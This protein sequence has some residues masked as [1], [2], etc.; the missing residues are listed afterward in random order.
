MSNS[1]FTVAGSA[2]GTGTV[3]TVSTGTG[4]TGGPI[5]TSGTVAI[6]NTAV[7]PGSYTNVSLTVNQQ[8]Q[9][10]AAS[11]GTPAGGTVTS[12]ATG[13][14]LTGGPVTTSGTISLV[15]PVVVA[16]GG[17]GL[18]TMANPYGVIVAGT[19]STG[20]LQNIATGSAGQVLA[21]NGNAA[22]PSFQT[23]GAGAGGGIVGNSK[24]L[25]GSAPGGTRTAVWTV[26]QLVTYTALAGFSFLGASLSLSFNGATTGANGM[27]IGSTP[28]S[29]NL[30]IYAIYNPTS[31]TWATLGTIVGSGSA[32]YTGVNM[33]AGFTY[34]CLLWA[35]IT[36]SSTNIKIFNQFQ[37]A[38]YIGGLPLVLNT[39]TTSP[40]A[41]T[42][43]SIASVVPT[44]ATMI[45]GIVGRTQLGNSG[46][47]ISPTSTGIGEQLMCIN[48]TNPALDGFYTGATFNDLMIVTA[49]TMYYKTA[50]TGMS[51]IGINKYTI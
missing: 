35:G 49:G 3:T 43:F 29:G 18:T 41:W 15:V 6:A 4:L 14:G 47:G 50:S 7:T 38:I 12:V 10:T 36:D 19:T 11:S 40:N 30:Y 13:T 1:A 31:M 24:N 17:T 46:L 9:L 33:P 48:G 2:T 27:D 23:F 32:L 25:K 39:M 45:S 26:D 44:G 37:N 21:S 51:A 5:T 28:M 34:S 22:V 42:S 20:A 8:G 16:D